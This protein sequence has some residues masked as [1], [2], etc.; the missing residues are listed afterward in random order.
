MKKILITGGN[1][2]LGKNLGAQLCKKNKVL[3]AL[4]IMKK[5]Y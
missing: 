2:F 4:E 3:M 1:G 5:T